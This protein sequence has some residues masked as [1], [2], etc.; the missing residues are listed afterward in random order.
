[1][2]HC[3][4]LQLKLKSEQVS[5]VRSWV[6]QSADYVLRANSLEKT[7]EKCGSFIDFDECVARKTMETLK[8]VMT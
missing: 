1:M 8:D 4:D 2:Y 3:Y 5:D 6:S 7:Q